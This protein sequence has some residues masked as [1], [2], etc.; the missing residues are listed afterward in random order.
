MF[1]DIG[2]GIILSVG[3]SKIFSVEL[4]W[5]LVFLGV[6]FALI[7]DFDFILALISKCFKNSFIKSYDFHREISHFP[8][9]YLIVSLLVFLFAGKF[10]GF[11]FFFGTLCH[12][13]HDSVGTGWGIKWFWPFSKKSYKLFSDQQGRLFWKIAIWDEEALHETQVKFGN[14][15]WIRDIYFRP[16]V[17]SISEFAILVV[18]IIVLIIN[19]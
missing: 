5:F 19:Q 18:G 12:F 13:L 11:L 9:I 3:V 4:T 8:I 6:I 17:V 16:T 14:P 15:N 7:P 2:I 10:F 1:A